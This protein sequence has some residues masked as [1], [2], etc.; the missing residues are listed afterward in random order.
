MAYA[1]INDEDAIKDKVWKY[2]ITIPKN[3]WQ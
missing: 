2:F 1:F 3:V